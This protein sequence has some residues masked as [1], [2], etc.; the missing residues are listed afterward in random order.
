[1]LHFAGVFGAL[2]HHV[3]EEMGEAGAATWLEAKADLIINADGGDGRGAV[4]RDD[5]AKAVGEGFAIDGDLKSFQNCLRLMCSYAFRTRILRSVAT[6]KQP[7]Q[8]STFSF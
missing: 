6:T 4:G 3:L 1:M 8:S 2:K 5:D 7:S